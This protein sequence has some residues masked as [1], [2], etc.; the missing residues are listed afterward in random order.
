[1]RASK[2]TV[3]SVY[4]EGEAW[5]LRAAPSS[6]SWWQRQQ[7]HLLLTVNSSAAHKL[8]VQYL[9]IQRTTSILQYWLR[10]LTGQKKKKRW[11]NQAYLPSAVASRRSWPQVEEVGSWETKLATFP[12][13][14]LLACLSAWDLAAAGSWEGGCLLAWWIPLECYVDSVCRAWEL[15]NYSGKEAP[16]SVLSFQWKVIGRFSPAVLLGQKKW[17]IQ[18]LRW[19]AL[20]VPAPAQSENPKHYQPLST[21]P[22]ISLSNPGNGPKT[23]EKNYFSV[24]IF[25]KTGEIVQKAGHLLSMQQS[26]YHPRH[27][28]WSP[29]CYQE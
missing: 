5:L 3:S 9:Q 15:G 11:S 22:G 21:E 7:C 27:P 1:M 12:N 10:F 8:L 25:H 29:E 6:T 4:T 17:N 2:S 13:V 19:L 14:D 28:I 23:T 18:G 16:V 24:F 26:Q 20:L